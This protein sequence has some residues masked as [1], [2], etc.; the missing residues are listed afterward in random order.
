MIWLSNSRKPCIT[1]ARSMMSSMLDGITR[2]MRPVSG[3]S[4]IH[5]DGR[6]ALDNSAWEGMTENRRSKRPIPM[7]ATIKVTTTMKA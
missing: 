4:V 3:L 6:H 1:R 2:C 5:Q 7:S